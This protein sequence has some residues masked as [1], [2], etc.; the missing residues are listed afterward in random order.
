MA[1]NMKSEKYI[2]LVIYIAVVVLLNIVGYSL[3]FRLDLTE[4]KIFSLSDISKEVVSTLTE[5]MTITV[6][7]SDDLPAPYNTTKRYLQ[8][9]LKEYEINGNNYFNYT[10]KDIS[11][12]NEE[13]EQSKQNKE[14]AESYGINPLKIRII[15]EDEMKSKIA[16]MGLVIIHGDLIEKIPSLTDMDTI[17]YT[18]TMR[19]KKLNNKISAL[20]ALNEKI[21]VELY[22]SS[23]LKDVAPYM[24]LND[25]PGIPGKIEST[26][27]KINL[28]N[29]GRLVY[30][31]IDPSLD[32]SLNDMVAKHNIMALKWNAIGDKVKAG[33]G[34]IGLV[35]RY[36]DKSV[37]IPL[38]HVMRIPIFGD[39]YELVNMDDLEEL[40]NGG[41][42]SL[43]D[44]N[45]KI[46]YLADHGTLDRTGGGGMMNQS[47]PEMN[48]F[49]TL[50]SQNY[51]LKD[52]NLTSEGIP[53][54]IQSLIIA[55]P[56]ENFTDYELYQIDQALMSGKN[57]VLFLDAFD[58]VQ[59]PNRQFGYPQG[60][61][62]KPINT[63]LEKLLNHYGISME[64]AYVLDENCFKQNL[65]QQ[66]G[67]GQRDIYFAPVIQNKNINNDIDFMK[68]INGLITM[69][70]SPLTI[71]EELIKK[72]D[73]KAYPLFSS[74][75]KSWGMKG[76]INL[77]P[78]FLQPPKN[79][80]EKKSYT[81]SYLLEGS[82]PSYFDGKPI[83]E[84]TVDEK[85][86]EEGENKPAEQKP[87]LSSFEAQ[88]GFLAKSKPAKI[89]VV[90]SAEMLKDSML[91]QEGQ[92][93]NATFILNA[94]D[95]L[96]GKDGIAQMRSKKQ[97]FNPLEQ[98]DA[99]VKTA[100]KAFNIAGLPVLV[101]MFGLLV[102]LKRKSRKKQIQMIFQK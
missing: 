34:G 16:Y 11:S 41:I 26:I 21:Q 91:D 86:D 43:I 60:P 27:E 49:N 18:L 89:L 83:P 88:G 87:D 71:N 93:P 17:E 14:L 64:K 30:K 28:K 100:F 81:L 75:D 4:N 55:N 19:M 42:E 2:K 51:S 5:P 15:E 72:H 44:I 69:R 85:K 20:L 7:F 66:Y 9:L 46:G 95:S 62:Y 37:D 61:A 10:F 48:S 77:N 74:S 102:W 84:K 63:G 50:V 1:S 31:Y 8:D 58:E 97:S 67:G 45:E 24:K 82:F 6:F 98:T 3:F 29:Y 54:D 12:A 79:D 39:Q 40:I 80:T 32:N 56:T 36:K 92:S 38:M 22:M 65:P 99:L 68:N 73:I 90:A 33:E 76:N 78:M 70:V 35:V 96:N 101:V 25:L 59:Q 53:G 13:S 52:I 47:Q 94:I 23:S 57:M